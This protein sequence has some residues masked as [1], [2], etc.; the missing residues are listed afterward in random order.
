VPHFF[1]HNVVANF[2]Q[3]DFINELITVNSEEC[4]YVSLLDT[5]F[6]RLPTTVVFKRLHQLDFN[7]AFYY[8][9]TYSMTLIRKSGST[10]VIITPENLDRFLYFLYRSKQEDVFYM[11]MKSVHFT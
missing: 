2:V 5:V 11:Y 9:Y 3:N 4:L 1:R 6:S 8:Y 7:G 10:F